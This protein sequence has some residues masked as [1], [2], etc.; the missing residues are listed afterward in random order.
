MNQ[1]LQSVMSEEEVAEGS[2]EV[3]ESDELTADK[4]ESNNEHQTGKSKRKGLIVTFPD[5]TVFSS[6]RDSRNQTE[7]W[8]KAILKLLE[9][10][11]VRNGLWKL[12]LRRGT[13]A[14]KRGL[15]QQMQPSE[16]D[17]PVDAGQPPRSTRRRVQRIS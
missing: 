17:L 2:V 12:T 9:Q 15:Y 10:F 11:G 13:L 6:D 16:I 5:G 1:P 8:V 7:V 14:V 4:V 3:E